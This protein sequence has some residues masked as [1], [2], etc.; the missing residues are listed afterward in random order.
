M[1]SETRKCQNCKTDFI[2]EPEDFDFYKK[3]DVPPPTFCPECRMM[4]RLA[5]R[6]ERMVHKRT[7]DLCGKG[8][9]GM[10][11]QK[12]GFPVY[13]HECWWSDNWDPLAG[14]VEYDF[15]RPFFD[16]FQELRSR[17]PRP[18]VNN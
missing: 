6:N 12:V 14:G 16:Q 15:E 5:F 7:C 10:F 4:R 1:N 11:P 9:V 13:C 18:G 2:I 8:F 17:V 3:I